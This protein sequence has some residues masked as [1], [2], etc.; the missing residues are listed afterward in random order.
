MC[1]YIIIENF[2]N[3]WTFIEGIINKTETINHKLH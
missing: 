2:V 3:I 1:K